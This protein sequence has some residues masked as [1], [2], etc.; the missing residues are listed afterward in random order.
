MLNTNGDD[1]DALLRTADKRLYLAK[2]Q[3]RNTVVSEDAAIPD[4]A[5]VY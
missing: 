4:R 5:V 2:A 3:G 1:L